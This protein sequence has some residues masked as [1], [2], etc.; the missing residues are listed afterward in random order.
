MFCKEFL[1]QTTLG[2]KHQYNFVCIIQ[3]FK[4]L[5]ENM[6]Q[7][8]KTNGIPIKLFVIFFAQGGM[9]KVCLVDYV[10]IWAKMGK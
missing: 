1:H 8:L 2:E 6:F 5:W 3:S 10:C 9:L 7:N 4:V